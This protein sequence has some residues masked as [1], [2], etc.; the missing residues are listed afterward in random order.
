[1]P[2]VDQALAGTGK[3][4]RVIFEALDVL[5]ILDFV[6][7]GLG[8]TLLP[9]YLATSRPDLKPPRSPNRT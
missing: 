7:H 4:R 5:T 1:V 2:L 8:F 3:Q 9:Q 6:A